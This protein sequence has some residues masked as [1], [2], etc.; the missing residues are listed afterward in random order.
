MH[1]DA[2]LHM[3]IYA[4]V[5]NAFCF[6]SLSYSQRHFFLAKI[7]SSSAGSF[8][9]QPKRDIK[10]KTDS[11]LYKFTKETLTS[12]SCGNDKQQWGGERKREPLLKDI[13]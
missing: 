9:L 2:Q 4:I 11:T 10:R 5:S 8:H 12:T 13:F 1:L 3:E 6:S 7:S